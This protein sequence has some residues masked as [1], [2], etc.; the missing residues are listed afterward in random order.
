MNFPSIN[1]LI[2]D[3]SQSFLRFPITIISSVLTAIIFIYMTEHDFSPEDNIMLFNLALMAMLNIGLSFALYLFAEKEQFSVSKKYFLQIISILLLVIYFFCLPSHVIQEIPFKPYAQYFLFA[4]ALHFFIAFLP[5][6]K[7]KDVNAFW[8]YNTFLFTRFTTAIFFSATLFLGLAFAYVAI[9]VLFDGKIEA[10]FYFQTFLF[11]SF[12]FNTWFFVAGIPDDL[13]VFD[14]K[15]QYNKAL[16]VFSQFILIPL[17]LIY[18]SILYLY[19]VKIALAWT[20]PRGMV[21][22]LIL[23]IAVLGILA[24]LFLYPLAQKDEN[25]WVKTISKAYYIVLIPLIIVLWLAIQVRVGSYG[26]TENRYFLILLASW[27]TF[28][29]LYFNLKKQANIKIIPIS[30]FLFITVAA[31]G[32]LSAFNVSGRSQ[33][34]RL[35]KVLEENNMLENNKFSNKAV[36]IE[37]ETVNN[38]KSIVRYLVNFSHIYRIEPWYD[39]DF[40]TLLNNARYNYEIKNQLIA[41]ITEGKE[42]ELTEKVDIQYYNFSIA[43]TNVVFLDSYDYIVNFYTLR[44]NIDFS[45]KIEDKRYEMRLKDDFNLHILSENDTLITFNIKEKLVAEIKKRPDNLHPQLKKLELVAENEKSKA[46]L[47]LYHVYVKQQ[48]DKYLLQN[49]EGNLLL[50]FKE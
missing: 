14:G 4:L 38:I 1:D 27:L 18:L 39:G 12:V 17:M 49:M 50:S 47:V 16:K 23:G 40:D 42:I 31:I 25:S 34:A 26:V 6:L 21:S 44:K 45:Y 24:L 46:K 7:T 28:I 9:S 33:T 22:S 8:S 10:Q 32:P 20:W 19:I 2:T 13:S 48:G 3:A 36:K 5:Y 15:I 29:S 43:K 37:R 41:L 11:I 30:I 35:I